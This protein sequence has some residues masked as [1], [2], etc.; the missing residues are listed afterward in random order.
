M[1]RLRRLLKA[2]ALVAG[3]FVLQTVWLVFGW[4]DLGVACSGRG[5]HTYLAGT[6]NQP[7]AE[8]Y[9]DMMAFYFGRHAVAIAPN[10]QVKVRPLVWYLENFD[11]VNYSERA[12]AMLVRKHGIKLDVDSRDLTCTT[13]REVALVPNAPF[14][15]R[16]FSHVIDDLYEWATGD[17]KHR[18][19]E[20]LYG[21]PPAKN[22]P[23]QKGLLERWLGC[24]DC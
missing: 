13:F 20:V 3:L 15:I 9:A 4:I 23:K 2:V 19:L 6:L 12:A 24:A 1:T 21:T 16:E 7:Y 14:E 18:I 8:A 5:R 11:I 10:G 17:T 22:W